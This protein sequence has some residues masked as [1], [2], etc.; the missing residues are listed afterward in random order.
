MPKDQACFRLSREAAA[1]YCVQRERVIG[2]TASSRGA[3]VKVWLDDVRAAPEGW[4]LVTSVT[5]AI[6]LLKSGEV[7]Q[8]SLDHDLGE[9]DEDGRETD[10]YSV[11]AWIEEHVVLCGFAPPRL[12][13]HS[14]NPPAHELCGFVSDT[15]YEGRLVP[16]E[17]C[18]RRRLEME[19][20][21]RFVPIEHVGNRQA[22][23][24]EV[25]FVRTEIERLVGSAFVGA[26]GSERPLRY[27]DVLVVAPYNMQVRRLRAALPDAVAVG[28][29]DK[30]QGQEAPVVFFSMTTSTGED[31][32]RG[33]EFLYSPNR[34]N[35]A[36][37]RA[38][39]L[40]YVVAS[41]RL[42]TADARTTEQMRLVNIVC[43]FAETAR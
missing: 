30:F 34:F 32:P 5:Q 15:F 36:I 18:E 29:V 31:L 33:I 12:T 22:A 37:S 38:Q 6:E 10:G 7:E 40:A 17:L 8:L 42:L 39:C 11:L 26:D 23:P 3:L 28:T 19:N 2:V 13:V 16:V 4:R 1:H 20:G 41:P 27:E 14:A 35:V 25:E 24:E 21:P 9:L 43:R